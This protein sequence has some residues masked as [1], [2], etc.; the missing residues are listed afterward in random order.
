MKKISKVESIID[1]F[2][3]P[4][5]IGEDWYEA[6]LKICA[7]CEYNSANAGVEG[8]KN[9]VI[10]F[11]ANAVNIVDAN[12]PQCNAC[13]CFIRRKAGQKEEACGLEEKALVPKWPRLLVHT[14]NSEDF[15]IINLSPSKVNINLSLDGTH[16]IVDYGMM[17]NTT[18]MTV[19]LIL[20]GTGT[21][22]T[23]TANCGCTTPTFRVLSPTQTE[24]TI[25]VDTSKLSLGVWGKRV[26]ITYKKTP[27][28][29]NFESI[30]IKVKGLKTK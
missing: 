16:Y 7:G 22:K 4:L 14:T 1:A 6:R 24:L 2:S 28:A 10:N 17:N 15:N 11:L 3:S 8:I 25:G 21:I 19:K 9:N 26:H 23:A 5:P 13:G 29:I 20:E 30:E 12:E 18:N 27:S